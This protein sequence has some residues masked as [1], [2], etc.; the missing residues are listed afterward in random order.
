MR[1]T[2]T[3]WNNR[4]RAPAAVDTQPLLN[5]IVAITAV[6]RKLITIANAALKLS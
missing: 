3:A 2:C 5:L 6:M 4:S 1:S